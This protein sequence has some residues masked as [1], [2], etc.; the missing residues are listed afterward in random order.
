MILLENNAFEKILKKLIPD[1]EKE[2]LKMR[3][4]TIYVEHSSFISELVR[5]LESFIYKIDLPA[6]EFDQKLLL[7]NIGMALEFTKQILEELLKDSSV[8]KSLFEPIMNNYR[9][10]LKALRT[11]TTFK[12]SKN[13]EKIIQKYDSIG[14]YLGS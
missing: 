7:T 3:P 4:V 10:C 5:S 11:I 1:F 8:K 9:L 12:N 2:K 6:N 13:F 14:V